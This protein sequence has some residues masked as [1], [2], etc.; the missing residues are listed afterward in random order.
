MPANEIPFRAFNPW[1]FP[2]GAP[3]NALIAHVQATCEAYEDQHGL[4][5]RK[6]RENDRR[7]FL[8]TV[9][10]IICDL[11]HVYHVGDDD[12]LGI[13]R[14]KAILGG[15]T[16]YRSPVHTKVLP[17]ILDLLAQPDLGW[18]IQE[19]G[20]RGPQE[21]QEQT[22]I[23]P[24]P[25]LL[26]AMETF[27]VNHQ[28]IRTANHGETIILKRE[29]ADFWD[30]GGKI[31]YSET[32]D[33][34]ALRATVADINDWLDAADITL[35]VPPGVALRVDPRERRLRRI[36]TQGRFDCGGRLFGGFWQSMSKAQ[37][38]DHILIDGERVVELDFSSMVLRTIYGLVGIDPGYGDLYHLDGLE[39]HRDGVKKVLNAMVSFSKPLE[40]YPRGTR[41]L[42]P[43]G[44]KVSEVT[45]KIEKR[46]EP[47]RQFFHTGF[48][49]QQQFIES[50]I[51]ADVLTACRAESLPALPIHDA[52]LVPEGRSEQ[53]MELMKAI[54]RQHTGINAKVDLNRR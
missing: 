34:T 13:S 22:K 53:A 16:R 12:Y 26:A 40:R 5:Q 8:R 21:G 3:A 49:H 2:S 44:L 37:R 18:I 24:G 54:F 47:I 25:S 45:A 39:G 50:S 11:I 17:D 29:L 51:L 28:G 38:F 46:H 33:T 23:W 41:D 6:R 4:R 14:S 20:T 35:S 31:E 43:E 19:V 1:R 30:D 52:L 7:S 15:K 42:F 48:V 27:K 9:E 32:D 36:F 10:A